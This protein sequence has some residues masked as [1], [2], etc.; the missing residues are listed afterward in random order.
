MSFFSSALVFSS[1]LCA[2]GLSALLVRHMIGLAVLD[3]PVHRS[4]HAVPTPK[5]GGIGVMAAFGLFFPIVQILAGQQVLS[6]SYL[7][8]FCALLLLCGVSWLDDLYQWSPL[9]KFTAQV[10]AAGLIVGGGVS[11]SWPTPL[12]GAA[13]SL[14][15]LIFI[16]NAIN[17]MD[18]LNGLIAGCLCCAA[19]ALAVAAPFMGV[20]ELVLPALLLASCLMGFLPFNFPHARIFLGDV[21]SQGCGL[22]A[23][24]AA[25]YIAAHTT[26]PTGWLLGPALLFPLIYDVAFT[27][28]RRKYM[29][30]SLIQAHRGHL[31]QILHRSAVPVPAVSMLEWSMTIW[32]GA[33]ACLVA[34]A[35]NVWGSISGITLLMLPQLA[36]TALAVLRAHKQ[37]VGR[38]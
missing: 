11:L 22:L 33:I 7:M 9:I 16:T 18:G 1:L 38:W 35:T 17:F 25:L 12:A 26:Q 19:L 34:P 30:D 31:Y 10:V 28:V 27:L 29:G 4:A 3:H 8:T 14:L 6:F 20:P 37:Q 32:G 23:G 2:G 36:W 24:T 15:W 21:G 5:G 13:L